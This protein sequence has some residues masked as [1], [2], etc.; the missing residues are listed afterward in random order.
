[1][2]AVSSA[3]VGATVGF[4]VVIM[5]SFREVRGRFAR[6]VE[7]VPGVDVP[8]PLLGGR[9]GTKR[10]GEGGGSASADRL[11]DRRRGGWDA[12]PSPLPKVNTVGAVAWRADMTGVATSGFIFGGSKGRLQG[13][14]AQIST[15][16]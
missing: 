9:T 14:S 7:A 8:L 4:S 1:M 5:V 2:A 16:I 6:S 10:A 11:A 3:G 15:R 12:V 13:Y